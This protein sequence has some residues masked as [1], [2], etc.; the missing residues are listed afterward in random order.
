MNR[1]SLVTAV[2]LSLSFLA[3]PSLGQTKSDEQREEKAIQL[4]EVP[5]VAREAAQRE[6]GAAP[7]GA[8]VLIGTDPPEYELQAKSWSNK[9]RSVRVQ[10]N[11][12]VTEKKI[13]LQP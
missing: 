6:L 2:V 12:T 10:A 13:Q 4:S 5:P 9:K 8:K 1:A 11:G 7:T 3:Q